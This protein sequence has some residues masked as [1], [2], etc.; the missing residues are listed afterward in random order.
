MRIPLIQHLASFSPIKK[1]LF[2]SAAD[3]SRLHSEGEE[4]SGIRGK[5]SGAVKGAEPAE[6]VGQIVRG[7]ALEVNHPLLESAAEGIDVL[8]MPGAADTAAGRHADG[9][10]FNAQRAGGRCQGTA[11][12]GAKYRV[13]GQKRT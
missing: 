7:E 9:V 11:A 4:Q 8:D 5:A 6:I 2:A 1:A 10:V 3:R 13:R 12:V